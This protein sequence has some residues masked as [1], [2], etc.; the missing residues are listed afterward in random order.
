MDV[1]GDAVQPAIA[2]GELI[3]SIERV[4]AE[5]PSHHIFKAGTEPMEKVYHKCTRSCP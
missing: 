2:L 4:M 3:F 5:K 1:L